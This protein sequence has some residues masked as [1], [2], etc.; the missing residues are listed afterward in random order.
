M[1]EADAPKNR[2]IQRLDRPVQQLVLA[3]H[4]E[5]SLLLRA[6][7]VSAARWVVLMLAGHWRQRNGVVAKSQR[8]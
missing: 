2:P 4:R 1:S 5:R 3:A 7:I 6:I 8:G